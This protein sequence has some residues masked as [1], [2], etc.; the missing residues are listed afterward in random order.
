MKVLRSVFNADPKAMMDRIIAAGGAA[1]IDDE[2]G[3]VSVYMSFPK[4][5]PPSPE[6][7]ELAAARAVVEAARLL[8]TNM[9]RIERRMLGEATFD[10]LRH[11]ENTVVEYIARKT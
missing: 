5:D 2:S 4:A 1:I 3:E 10:R 11:L 8:V 6:E 9:A 7:T